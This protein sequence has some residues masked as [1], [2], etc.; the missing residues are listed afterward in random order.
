MESRDKDVVTTTINSHI[1]LFNDDP[2][3]ILASFSHPHAQ[4]VLPGDSKDGP[5]PS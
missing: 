2:K 3:R 5:R 1:E 4:L